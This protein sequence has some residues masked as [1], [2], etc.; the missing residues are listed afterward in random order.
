MLIVATR[1]PTITVAIATLGRE[2]CLIELL[3]SLSQQIRPADEIIISDQN[4]PPIQALDRF[5]EQHPQI[6]RIRSELKGVVA[7]MNL[8]LQES[9]SDIVLYLDDDVVV[10]PDLIEKHLRNYEDPVIDAVAVAFSQPSG[11]LPESQIRS[12]GRYHALTGGVTANFNSCRRQYCDI[13]QG[14]N[15]S[16]RRE[17]MMHAGGFEVGCVGNG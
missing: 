8:L 17:K 6:R 9:T 10:R 2:E 4:F 16:M 3:D 13:A 14:L 5:L 7:N 15:M 12:V 1:Q 11:D